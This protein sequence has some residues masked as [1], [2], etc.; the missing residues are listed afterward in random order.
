MCPKHACSRHKILLLEGRCCTLGSG[1]H[2]SLV[3]LG[4]DDAQ[5]AFTYGTNVAIPPA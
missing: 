5:H 2:S 3:Q 4:N 1:G